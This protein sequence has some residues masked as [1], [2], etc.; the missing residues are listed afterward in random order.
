VTSN[1]IHPVVID[2]HLPAGMAGPAPMDFDVR[3]F[4]I[5]HASGVTLVDTGLSGSSAVIG[6]SLAAI[7]AGWSDVTDVILSHHHPD[8]IGGLP[9]VCGLTPQ[10]TM[11]ASPD[12]T[13]PAPARA[14]HDG[15]LIRGMQVIATPGHTA[16][17][18][19]LLVA[20]FGTLLIGDLVGTHDGQLMRAPAAF[21]AD[22]DQAERSLRRTSAIDFQH[23]LPAHGAPVDQPA[24]ALGRLLEV[25]VGDGDPHG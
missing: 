6:A 24:E 17:H 8:H 9:E 15:L 12:D 1:R 22:P 4:L 21:T 25:G 19:S 13:F 11:W 18:L 16:G 5:P 20:E 7:G 3:C 2:V 14:A 10:A 23:L